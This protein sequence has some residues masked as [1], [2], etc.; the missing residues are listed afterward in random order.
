MLKILRQ[1]KRAQKII[2]SGMVVVMVFAF[3]LWG[4]GAW[5]QSSKESNY[6]GVIFGR[7]VSNPE[8]RKIRLSCLNDLKFRFGENYNVL[9]QF[10]DLNNQAW[11]KLIL[12]EYAK[13]QKITASNQEVIDEIASNPLFSKDGKFNQDTY[14]R[15]IRYFLGS[16]PREFEEQTRNNLIIRKLYVQATKDAAL[17]DTEVL[18]AYKKDNETLSVHYIQTDSKN[19]LSDIKTSEDELKDYYQK[20]SSQFKRPPTVKI[21]YIGIDYPPDSKEAQMIGVSE[22]MNNIHSKIKKSSELKSLAGDNV[23]HKESGFFASDEPLEGIE[24]EEFYKY[25]FS[26]GAGQVSPVIKTLKG[27]YILKVIRKKDP[28]IPELTETRPKAEEALK[29]IKAKEEARKK[30]ED[31]RNKIDGYLK[32]DQAINLKKAAELLGVELKTTPAFKRGQA[33]PDADIDLSVLNSAFELKPGE[34]SPILEGAKSIFIVEPDKFTGIDQEK[35]KQDKAAFSEN[36]LEKKKQDAFNSLQSQLIGQANLK[37][38]IS[39]S[40]AFPDIA[41]Q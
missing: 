6:S 14:G 12:L 22:Q 34:I 23:I 4:A 15:I 25:A 28:Y 16:Q 31:Y 41:D 5:K 20:N 17:T 24:S 32:N 8:F 27:V 33:I 39:S 3:V 11:I 18:E 29:L 1:K 40:S 38:Y 19:F 30:A 21:E 26:L 35:F 37:Q 2:L 9:L 13:K 7:R 10:V 36:L